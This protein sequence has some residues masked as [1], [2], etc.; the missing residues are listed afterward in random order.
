MSSFQYEKPMYAVVPQDFI[1]SVMIAIRDA[2]GY[3]LGYEAQPRK[4]VYP[5]VGL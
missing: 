4:V 2:K 5:N 3:I 1:D